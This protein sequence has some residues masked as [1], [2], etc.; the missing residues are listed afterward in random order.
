MEDEKIGGF[1][2]HE[3]E[4]AVRTLQEACE[5]KKDEKLMEALQPLLKKKIKSLEELRAVAKEKM[6]GSDEDDMEYEYEENMQPYAKDRMK[7]KGI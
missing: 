4:S 5:I 3:L 1:Y 6:Y 7:Q 2:K